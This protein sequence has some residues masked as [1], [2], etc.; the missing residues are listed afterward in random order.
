[1]PERSYVECGGDRT[2][3]R[4]EARWDLSLHTKVDTFARNSPVL[5]I[6]EDAHWSDPTSLEALPMSFRVLSAITTLFDSAVPCNLAARFG[7]SPTMACSWDAPEPI[8]SPTT[9]SPVAMPTS[10]CSGAGLQAADCCANSSLARTAR[11]ASS[12]CAWG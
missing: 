6:L 7:V 12:S 9:T 3:R 5:M 10:V 4:L 8:R 1:V 2:G 11:S